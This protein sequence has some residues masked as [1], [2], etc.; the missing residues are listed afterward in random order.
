MLEILTVHQHLNRV[1]KRQEEHDKKLEKLSGL[2]ENIL[3]VLKEKQVVESLEEIKSGEV[4][5]ESV[6]EALGVPFGMDYEKIK[7]VGALQSN[8]A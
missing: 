7:E 8:P 2:M 5:A 6:R 3:T 1:E 4:Q